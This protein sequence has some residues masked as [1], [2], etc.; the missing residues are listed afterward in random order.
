MHICFWLFFLSTNRIE[1]SADD[2]NNLMN[3]HLRFSS[4]YFLTV[5]SWSSLM[6]YNDFHTGF[7]SDMS[8]ILWSQARCFDKHISDCFTTLYALSVKQISSVAQLICE[9]TFLSHDSLK[10]IVYLQSCNTFSTMICLFSWIFMKIF[11]S[12]L[13]E[14]CSLFISSAWSS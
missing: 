2:L 13:I 8:N 11:V 12:V 7:F 5:F 1:Y 9:L 14:S 4:R 10:I 6:L 3:S